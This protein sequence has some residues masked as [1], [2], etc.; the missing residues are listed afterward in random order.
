MLGAKADVLQNIFGDIQCRLK[1]ASESTRHRYNLGR[2]DDAYRLHQQVW[3][4]N[5]VLSNA[6]NQ[7]TAKLAPKFVGPFQVSKVVSPWTYEL[8]D[9]SGRNQGV[10]HAK[11]LKSHP[12]DR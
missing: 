8:V 4:K 5:Y 12:P 6:V 11:D 7:F 10:W 2:R 9:S 1:K 3:Q